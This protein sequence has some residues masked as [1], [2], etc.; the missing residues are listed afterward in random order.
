MRERNILKWIAFFSMTKFKL[1]FSKHY[2]SP[3]LINLQTSLLNHLVLSC[4]RPK[5][6]D[7]GIYKREIEIE[8]E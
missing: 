7:N 1:V 2:M 8:E 4:G 5:S 3:L 6:N